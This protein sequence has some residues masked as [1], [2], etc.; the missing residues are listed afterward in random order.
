MLQRWT[1]AKADSKL[2]KSK[3]KATRKTPTLG[4]KKNVEIAILLEFL[5][6]FCWTL[7]IAPI[8]FEIKFILT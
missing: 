3:I 8:N 2:F 7:E 1:A 5:S 6:N 4:K